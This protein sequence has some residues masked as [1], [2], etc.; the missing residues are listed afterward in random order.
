MSS[1]WLSEYRR[2]Y[3][4][5]LQLP[6]VR[7]LPLR[8]VLTVLVAWFLI[9]HPAILQID[10]NDPLVARA[11]QNA[12]RAV[13]AVVLQYEGTIARLIYDDKGTRFKIAFGMP[14][15][16]HEGQCV[17]LRVRSGCQ[18]SVLRS[19]VVGDCL[20]QCIH[21]RVHCCGLHSQMME[22]E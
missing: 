17:V 10:Y 11:L 2:V 9:G 21:S 16:S 3:V 22:C 18:N 1:G 15:A 13:Q 4:M 14:S 7:I 20:M 12:V 8:V 5:M 19:L 6:N